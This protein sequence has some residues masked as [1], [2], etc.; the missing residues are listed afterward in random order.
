MTS[1]FGCAEAIGCNKCEYK[2]ECLD[3]QRNS[4]EE[5]WSKLEAIPKSPATIPEE[6]HLHWEHLAERRLGSENN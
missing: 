2:E 5:E 4:Y 3:E 6:E 1:P